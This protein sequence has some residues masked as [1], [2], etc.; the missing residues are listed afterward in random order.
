MQQTESKNLEKLDFE[1]EVYNV[2]FLCQKYYD[3][4]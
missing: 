4:D 2:F 1:N 3:M